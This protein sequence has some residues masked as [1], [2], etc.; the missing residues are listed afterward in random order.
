MNQKTWI[1]RQWNQA[2]NWFY[3]VWLDTKQF[4]ATNTEN[5]QTVG[6]TDN[7][8]EDKLDVNSIKVYDSV[9]G[10]DVTSK[11]D[12]ANTGGV[13]TATL[14]AGFTKS[15]GDANNTQIIDTTKFAFGRYYKVDIVTTVKTSVEPGKDIE[16]TAGQIVHYY[17]PRTNKV[18][19]RKTNWKTC[20]K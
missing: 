12:I 19:T 11:F 16:N 14:K 20:K 4:S 6:I 17:N 13:I 7:Y 5:I 3:Q 2:I 18:E 9:T 8:D 10:T 15:L 1:R